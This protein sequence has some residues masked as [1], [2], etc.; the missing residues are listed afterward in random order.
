MVT[1]NIGDLGNLRGKPLRKAL[2][3]G[4]NLPNGAADFYPLLAEV[5][6][7]VIEEAEERIVSDRARISTI[8]YYYT[9]RKPHSAQYGVRIRHGVVGAVV[10]W[11]VHLW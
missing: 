2:H 1:Q 7:D 6:K 5:G 8:N 4:G 9:Y 11:I 3:T 10:Y